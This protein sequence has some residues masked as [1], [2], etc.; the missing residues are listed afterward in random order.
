MIFPLL[1]SCLHWEIAKVLTGQK[2]CVNTTKKDRCP[3]NAINS[4][5]EGGR[6]SKA[7]Y[8]LP[9]CIHTVPGTGCD[10]MSLMSK[11]AKMPT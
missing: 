2:P 1:L 6:I 5:T 8:D 3:G 7:C 9:V 10:T 4:R 11:L